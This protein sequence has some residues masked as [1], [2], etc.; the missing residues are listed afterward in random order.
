MDLAHTKSV[1]QVF[2]HF[3][4][5]E[6]TGLSLSEVKL[7]QEKYGP[8]GEWEAIYHLLSFLFSFRS[9]VFPLALMMKKTTEN[10]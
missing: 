9:S 3:G 10:E 1:E 4:V 8:N 2:E 6:S 5:N 7:S